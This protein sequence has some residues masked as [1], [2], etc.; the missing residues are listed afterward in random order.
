VNTEFLDGCPIQAPDGLSLY[1]ATNRPGG[2]GG[3]DI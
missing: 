1:M 3:M 2:L